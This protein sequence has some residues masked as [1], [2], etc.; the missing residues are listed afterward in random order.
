MGSSRAAAGRLVSI[1]RDVQSAGAAAALARH[2][3]GALAGRPADE[4]FLH[5][6][7]VV[8]PP[9][10]SINEA[11]SRQ[12]LLDAILELTEGGAANFDQLSAGQWEEFLLSFIG[13]S[14]EGKILSDIGSQA[15]K[16]P[17]SAGDVNALQDQMKDFIR[18]CT[19]ES[20]SDSLHDVS[21]LTDAEIATCIN[22][23]YEAAFQ[24][25]SLLDDGS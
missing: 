3:L 25:I 22:D 9:G 17:E 15:L 6:I 13:N 16:I 23:V 1:A 24:Y 4:V 19:R 12:A 5:L 18:G 10:G 21:K 8:C 14:I 11:I 7:E 20:L 2:Q